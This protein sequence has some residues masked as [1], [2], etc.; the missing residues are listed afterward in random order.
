M[1]SAI[2]TTLPPFVL[3]SI[4]ISK[5]SVSPTVIIRTVST[6]GKATPTVR[7]FRIVVYLYIKGLSGQA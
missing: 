1:G 3:E 5:Q 7:R 4:C 6:A 2:L